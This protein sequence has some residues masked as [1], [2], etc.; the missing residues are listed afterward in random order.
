MT[1][2]QAIK[3]VELFAQTAKHPVLSASEIAACLGHYVDE[4]GTYT[5]TGA[6][7]AVCDAWDIKAAKA[8]DHHDVDVNGRGI[9][10]SQ[11]IA[12][13]ERMGARARRRLPV[14]VA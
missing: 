7:R 11:V 5:T 1:Q 2:A 12:N 6:Q 3:Y 14:E 8:A 13:C 9:S 4:D 10:A